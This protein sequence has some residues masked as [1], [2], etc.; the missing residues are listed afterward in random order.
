[1]HV[2]LAIGTRP[3]AIKVAPLYHALRS[4]P[5]FSVTTCITSQHREL[6]QQMLAFFD[7]RPDVD[8][9]VMQPRQTLAD[10]TCNVLRG[11]DQQGSI[12]AHRRGL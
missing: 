11:A 12:V 7:V 10:L 6:L 1:M 2:L 5:F 4:D 8:L 3:E 9:Q